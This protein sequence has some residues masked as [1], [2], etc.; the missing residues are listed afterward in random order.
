MAIQ[1]IKLNELQVTVTESYDLFICSSSFESRCLSVAKNLNFDRIK[2]SLILTNEDLI[3]YIGKNKDILVRYLGEKYLSVDI[4]T[5]D[6]LLTADNISNVLN[7]SIQSEQI[8]SILIDVTAFTHESLLI[9]LRLVQIYFPDSII[10]GIYASASEYS[11]GDDIDQKWLSRGIGDVR[12][13][14]GYPGQIIPSKK[15]HLIVI[16]G[17]EYERATGI[18]EAL[19]PNSISLGYGV[20]GSATTEKNKD[21]NERYM[22]LVQQVATSFTNTNCFEIPCDNPYLSYKGIVSEIDKAIQSN[23]IIAPMNNKLTTIGV[24]WAAF[25]NKDVQLCYA[26]TLCYNYFNYSN[27]SE[28]CYIF[29]LKYCNEIF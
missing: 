6:P 17:Y 29:D 28:Y 13:V 23:V 25:M 18:I 1:K 15:N 27:P 11:I 22:H 7:N 4:S 10:S 12:P 3:E 9:I 2:K 24:A 8:N 20:S 21:A 5:T 16:V 14:L 26:K 19:E